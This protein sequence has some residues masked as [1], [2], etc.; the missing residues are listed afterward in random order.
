MDQDRK[1][2]H[3]FGEGY[4]KVFDLTTNRM[5]DHPDHELTEFPYHE[6][7]CL[8]PDRNAANFWK[9]VWSNH[10]KYVFEKGTMVAILLTNTEK[11]WVL[12]LI[13]VAPAPGSPS[14]FYQC[15]FS[16]W[17]NLGRERRRLRILL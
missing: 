17:V 13:A 6:T 16:E 1:E 3:A 12:S 10:K 8:V 5:Q 4:Y 2:V 9:S 14:S 7:A 11:M 15:R